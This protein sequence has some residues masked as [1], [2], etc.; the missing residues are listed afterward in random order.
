[1]DEAGKK[2]GDVIWV[3]MDALSKEHPVF[4]VAPNARTVYV[5]DA[6]DLARRG[7][8]LKRCV[9]VMEC[10]EAMDVEVL[11]GKMHEVLRDLDAKRLFHAK[12]AD[13]ALLA[14]LD[15][16]ESEIIAVSPKPFTNVPRDTD[17]GRFFRFWNKARRSAMSPTPEREDPLAT[18]PQSDT[19]P[20]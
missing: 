1:M 15:G 11:Q 14:C 20:R 12:T 2:I 6:D 10:V 13:P 16:L 7:W 9:F 17:M 4:A 3:H 5:W 19:S 18:L 8:T